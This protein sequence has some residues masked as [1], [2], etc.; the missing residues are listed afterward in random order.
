MVKMKCQQSL[1]NQ[2]KLLHKHKNRS[3]S[4]IFGA[5][6]F[7]TMFSCTALTIYFFAKGIL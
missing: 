2:K 3:L 5:I 1:A 4:N 6:T 7:I